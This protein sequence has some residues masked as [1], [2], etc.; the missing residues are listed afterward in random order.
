[1]ESLFDRSSDMSSSIS[2]FFHPDQLLFKPVYEWAFGDKI[3]HPETTARAESILRAL[4]ADSGF[5]VRAPARVPQSAIRR[6]HSSALITLF[7]SAAQLEEGKTFYPSVF[8][9]HALGV[10]NPADVRHAGAFCFDSG[11]PL[12]RN[13]LNAASWSS[14][15]AYEAAMAVKAGSKLTYALSRPPGH[16]ATR[17]FFGGYSYFNNSAIAARVLR[18]L[19]KVAILDIDFHHGNGTQSIFD[20]D[21]RVLTVSLHGDPVEYYPYF[22]GFSNETGAGAGRGFNANIPLPGGSDGAIFLRA[23]RDR[24]LPMLQTFEPDYLVVAAGL[25]T[26]ELDPIGDFALRTSDFEKVGRAIGGLS[27]PTVVVQ[28]GG[29]HA[30]HLGRNVVALLSGLGAELGTT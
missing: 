24:A 28:E 13:T 21:P 2:C 17:H 8:P 14:A 7:S 18:P 20:R 15:C 9:G 10:G 16:H 5:D 27:L 22:S 26:Y 29:Y 4:T 11:T 1:M 6:T 23:L 30:E 25:D 3:A 19:G 12:C